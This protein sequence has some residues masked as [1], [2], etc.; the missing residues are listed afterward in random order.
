MSKDLKQRVESIIASRQC[1]DH[2]C[3]WGHPGGMGTNG[4]CR[5]DDMNG[6]DLRVELRLLAT[7]IRAAVGA[8]THPSNGAP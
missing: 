1:T 3:M 5:H 7:E 2:M 6:H 8:V 4:G